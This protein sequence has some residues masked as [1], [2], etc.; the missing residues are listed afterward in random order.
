[1]TDEAQAAQDTAWFHEEDGQRKGP[2]SDSEMVNLIKLAK[3]SYGSAVWKKGFPDWLKVENTELAVHLAEVS[4]PPLSGEH[5]NNTIV[6]I[7]A[8]A[9][10]IGLFLE[11]LVAMAVYGNEFAAQVAVKSNKLWFITVGLNIGLGFFDE[12]RLKKAGHNTDK[13][14]GWVW[15]VPVYLY[16]RA[17]HMK[18]NL[19]YFIVWLVCMAITFLD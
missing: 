3:V 10:L 8:F 9:P 7:L 13:F 2:V 17:K 12:R 14:K 4:P 16:Q 15:I 6:W 11:Y 18:Q 19:A 1:M 5:V